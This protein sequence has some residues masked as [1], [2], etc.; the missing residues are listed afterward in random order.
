M[1]GR[2]FGADPT[3]PKP[4]IYSGSIMRFDIPARVVTA[5]R[6]ADR[7]SRRGCRRSFLRGPKGGAKVPKTKF[8]GFEGLTAG[9]YEL[10]LFSVAGP[11]T[12][13]RAIVI[14]G[15]ICEG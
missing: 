13:Y 10:N 6:A 11:C 2:A 1:K 8:R 3:A 4:H 12:G 14:Y 9:R 7:T 5:G 15:I